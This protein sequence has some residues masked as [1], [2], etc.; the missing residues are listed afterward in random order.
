MVTSNV[1]DYDA[2]VAPDNPLGGGHLPFFELL[3]PPQFVIT[4]PTTPSATTTRWRCGCT[5]G[6]PG[7]WSLDASLVWSDL[8][9]QRGLRC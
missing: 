6:T 9:G 5:S 2:L 1:D 8:T 3:D 7:R 4:N